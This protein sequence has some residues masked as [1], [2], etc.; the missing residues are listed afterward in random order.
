MR[1]LWLLFAQSVTVLVAIWFVLITL[2]PEWLQRP[3]L[4]G[5]DVQVLQAPT[6]SQ[7]AASTGSLS[8]AA[9]RASPSVVSINTASRQT[10]QADRM[11]DPWF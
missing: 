6:L 8:M 4:W 5:P 1:R 9:K 11:R 2:K 3:R 10:N 7:Q